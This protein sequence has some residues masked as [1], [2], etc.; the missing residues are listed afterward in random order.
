MA[1]STPD[2]TSIRRG[3]DRLS[4]RTEALIV[5]LSDKR[6]AAQRTKQGSLELIVDGYAHVLALDVDRRRLE[7]ELV[8][9]AQDGDPDMA[10]ELSELSTL[11]HDMVRA[12]DELRGRLGELRARVESESS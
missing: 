7:R 10:G 8:R 12:S 9:L 2:H 5:T 6:A 1:I 4:R 3:A 11:L